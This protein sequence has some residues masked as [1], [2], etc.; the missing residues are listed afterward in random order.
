M[1]AARTFRVHQ[2]PGPLHDRLASDGRPARFAV[3]DCDGFFPGRIVAG[4]ADG[5]PYFA[6][7][8]EAE[9]ARDEV[10]RRAAQGE[11]V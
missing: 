6:T 10:A 7:L 1:T 9:A 4:P 8:E 2:F 5:N 3:L 11:V